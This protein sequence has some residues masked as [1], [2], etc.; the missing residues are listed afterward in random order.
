[1]EAA[2]DPS[3]WPAVREFLRSFA[4][5]E[6]WSADMARRLEAVAEEALL[7]LVAPPEEEV[8]AR[9]RRSRRLR[10]VARPRKDG[11]VLEFA[12]APRGDNIQDQLA[13]L[14]A[15]GDDGPVDRDVSLRLLRHLASSVR[16]QQYHDLDI[17]IVHVKADR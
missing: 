10:L 5:R 8:V 13:V 14:A 7:T 4:A 12:A 1:M 15:P 3:S 17:V 16:H 11:A 2:L 6:R 9:P